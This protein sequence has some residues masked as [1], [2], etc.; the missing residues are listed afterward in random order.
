MEC[1]R[2]SSTDPLNSPDVLSELNDL[3]V[4]RGGRLILA[5]PS[6]IG[7]PEIEAF[8]SAKVKDCFMT[9]SDHFRGGLH[10]GPQTSKRR[11]FL[12]TTWTCA[13]NPYELFDITNFYS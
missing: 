12:P 10:L 5:A 4:N 2:D 6:G 13:D 1:L 9:N 7:A 11:F 8:K 3:A